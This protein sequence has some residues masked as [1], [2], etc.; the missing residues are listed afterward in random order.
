MVQKSSYMAVLE[1]FFL[2][3]T[4]IHFIR[5]I[6]KR[7]SL[8]PTSVRNNISAMLKEGLIKKKSANPFNGFVANRENEDFLFYKR[9]YNLYSLRELAKHLS[10]QYCPKLIAV[11][12]SYGRGEDVE[13]SDVDIAIV[14]KPINSMNL[15]KYEEKL[16]RKIHCIVM[17]DISKLEP[18]MRKKVYNGIV[19][20]GGF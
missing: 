16:K 6:S 20:F 19:L 4:A 1:I 12:G 5:E 10:S 13:E 3:P 8:A 17:E 18:N 2:E 9:V 7:I 11:F 15:S 14:S